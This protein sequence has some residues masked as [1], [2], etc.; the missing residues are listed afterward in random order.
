MNDSVAMHDTDCL[1]AQARLAIRDIHHDGN[2]Q[3]VSTALAAVLRCATAYGWNATT[4]TDLIFKAW[5][6]RDRAC[7]TVRR[8]RR[9][10]QTGLAALVLH[11]FDL[12]KTVKSIEFMSQD[13]SSDT[14][15]RLAATDEAGA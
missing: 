5:G 10:I 3:D 2:K 4:C 11:A 12:E 9:R 7:A 1:I 14:P 13:S 8:R 6:K 15:V